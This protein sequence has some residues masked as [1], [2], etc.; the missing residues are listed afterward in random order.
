MKL[1]I[2]PRRLAILVALAAI[3]IGDPILIARP[4]LAQQSEPEGPGP[5][6]VRALPHP[7]YQQDEELALKVLANV[8]KHYRE[9]ADAGDAEAQFV[10]GMAFFAGTETSPP[11]YAEA[12]DW[13][14]KS[15]NGG[16]SYAPVVLAGMF[17]YGLGVDKD[18]DK[19]VEWLQVARERGNPKGAYD[20]AKIYETGYG[21]VPKDEGKALDLYLEAA[22]GG[23]FMA[24]L[25]LGEVYYGGDLGVA[26]DFGKAVEWFLAAAEG[27]HFL[28]YRYLATIRTEPRGSAYEPVDGLKWILIDQSVEEPLPYLQ[29]RLERLRETLSAE[30]IAQAEKKATEWIESHKSELPNAEDDFWKPQPNAA[31]EKFFAPDADF[32]LQHLEI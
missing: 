4:V 10:I 30:Q 15:A 9:A 27:Q 20:L 3:G 25:E 26:K 7:S 22:N 1:E 18:P 8:K 17:Q 5:A 28:A 13:L 16:S 6:D 11:N 2:G 31:P 19:M 14:L 32:A 24:A 29:E 21:R 12:Y 23:S